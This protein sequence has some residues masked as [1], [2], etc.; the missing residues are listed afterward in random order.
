M[1]PPSMHTEGRPSAE[2]LYIHMPKPSRPAAPAPAA[3]GGR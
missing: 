3:G 1:R 2:Q